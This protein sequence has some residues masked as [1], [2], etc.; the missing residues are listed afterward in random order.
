MNGWVIGDIILHYPLVNIHITM[1][2][3]SFLMQKLTIS[4]AILNS[5]VSLPQGDHPIR[6]IPITMSNR[7]RDQMVI[8]I[9]VDIPLTIPFVYPSLD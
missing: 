1:E 3:H 4:T 5:Y 8:G 2:H 9:T 7:L 6:L